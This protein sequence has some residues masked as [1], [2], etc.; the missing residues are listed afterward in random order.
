MYSMP[1]HAPTPPSSRYGASWR[2]GHLGGQR[3]RLRREQRDR[4][5]RCGPSGGGAF[6]CRRAHCATHVP[7]ARPAFAPPNANEFD[8]VRRGGWPSVSPGATG[9]SRQR[10]IG[11]AIPEMRREPPG[12]ILVL[13]REP[14]ERRLERAGRAER[15][16]AERLRGAHRDRVAQRGVDAHAFRG[17]VLRRAGAMEIDVFDRRSPRSPPRASACSIAT[18]APSPWD[19]APRSDSRR[20]SLP[21]RAGSPSPARGS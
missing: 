9:R 17:V 21:S 19:R 11:D 18:R 3:V 16:T 4:A 2:I 7:G 8:S 12:A 14:A 13:H 6:G 1:T 10:R 5:A 20:S 15:V